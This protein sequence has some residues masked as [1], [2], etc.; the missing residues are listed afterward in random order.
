MGGD[1]VEPVLPWDFL[2]PG[3]CF[4]AVLLVSGLIYFRRIEDVIVDVV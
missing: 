2:I 1:R 4:L 3:L